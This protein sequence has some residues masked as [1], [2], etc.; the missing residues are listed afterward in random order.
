MLDWKVIVAV[1]AA[2][3]VL[4]GGLLKDVSDGVQGE[5]LKKFMNRLKD[6][7]GEVIDFSNFQV[8]AGRDINVTGGASDI[9]EL[10][11]G[12]TRAALVEVKYKP[13]FMN[14]TIDGKQLTSR[15]DVAKIT[16]RGYRGSTEI[17][18][19]KIELDG[20]SDSVSLEGYDLDSEKEIKIIM[21]GS[22]RNASFDN[23]EVNSLKFLDSSGEINIDSTISISLGESPVSLKGFLGNMTFSSGNLN[24]E[25]RVRKVTSDS[26]EVS[27][28]SID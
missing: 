8:Q 3:L 18:S 19:D 24:L 22:Y 9:E 23:I 26:K 6:N 1:I 11:F 28:S 25:G 12:K 16:I 21:E 7:L 17:S 10:E 13:D 4:S 5:D 2:F 20:G 14:A 27:V 15:K